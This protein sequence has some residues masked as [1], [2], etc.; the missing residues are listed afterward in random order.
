MFRLIGS[1][2]VRK[3]CCGCLPSIIDVSD[4]PCTTQET[5]QQ[6]HPVLFSD[7][8]IYVIVYS[9]QAEFSLSDLTKHLM[10]VTVRCQEAPIVLV[11]THS[12]VIGGDPNLPLV[13]LKA[14]FPQVCRWSPL[15]DMY[16]EAVGNLDLRTACSCADQEHQRHSV[17]Q[18]HRGRCCLIHSAHCCHRHGHAPR[19]SN[20]TQGVRG[21][22]Q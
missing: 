16:L 19:Q 10:N 11:G 9:L 3:F 4:C 7:R 13:A 1:P 5:Y 8:A 18:R 2:L 14:K 17:V 22:G 12:D 6:T 20:R 21:P 15:V